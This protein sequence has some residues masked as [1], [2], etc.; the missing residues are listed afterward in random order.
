MVTGVTLINPGTGYTSAPMI[1]FTGGGGIGA[2]ATV[3]TTLTQSLPVQ[4]KAIQELF[5]PI[6]GRMNA[7]LGVELPFTSALTQT[8]IPLDYIDPTTETIADGETQIWK[9]THNGVDT[10]PVHFHQ[11]NVQLINR[12][13]WDGTVKPPAAEVGWKETVKMNPLEDIVVA[14]RAKRPLIPFGVPQSSVR[15]IRRSRWVPPWASRRSIRPP[16][17]RWWSPMRS[18]ITTTNTYGTAISWAMRKTISCVHSC[19]IQVSWF[20]MHPAAW[21]AL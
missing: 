4:N 9:I 3:T 11:V 5:D 7:T 1:T 13:G 6:Y 18:P 14:V 2:T 8:T 20:R 16:T 12:I 17:P 19:F 10:H 21:Q 15:W